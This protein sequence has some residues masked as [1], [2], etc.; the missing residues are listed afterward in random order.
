MRKRTV[1]GIYGGSFNPIHNAHLQLA[2]ALCEACLVENLWF[3]VSPQNPFKPAE[4]LLDDEARL[5]LARLAVQDSPD[6]QVSDVEFHLPRP[7]YMART[8]E[9]LRAQY[10]EREFV[11]VMGADNWERFPQWFHHEDILRHHRIIVYPRP[12]YPL[13]DMS[14]G[15]LV[16]DTPLIP[17]CSTAIRESIRSGT[18]RGEGLPPLVWKE[19]KQK[20]YYT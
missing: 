4:G 10:P 5:A 2:R 18:C 7:S 17:L 3:M 12:G 1:T 20:G 11:L 13:P 16:A 9:T 15:V 6:V 14:P 8:L 19:I